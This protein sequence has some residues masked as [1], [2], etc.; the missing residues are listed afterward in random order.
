MTCIPVG[1]RSSGERTP[2]EIVD[3]LDR[4]QV[5]RVLLLFIEAIAR[6]DRETD[7]QRLVNDLRAAAT[8]AERL[9]HVLEAW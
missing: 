9:T 8:T 7:P 5:R 4:R 2:A 1:A 6:N 3:A